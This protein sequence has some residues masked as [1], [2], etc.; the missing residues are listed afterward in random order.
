MQ[1]QQEGPMKPIVSLIGNPDV[2][3]ELDLAEPQLKGIRDALDKLKG[4]FLPKV[5]EMQK[6]PAEEK[7]TARPELMR[8][9][10]NAAET[11]LSGVMRPDQFQ[12][13][14]Q[15]RL[16]GEGI[17]A[18]QRDEVREKLNF[19]EEQ[20]DAIRE[21]VQTTRQRLEEAQGSDEDG[22][23]TQLA[24]AQQEALQAVTELFSEEQANAW[25]EMLGEQM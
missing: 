12:R 16:Q 17:V 1:A 23:P 22:G 8:D 2:Q 25:K 10:I 11:A 24:Q 3:Q 19:T 7:A 13:F 9:L 18:F 20:A 21:I 14:Q 5:E 6:L 4:E 15:L